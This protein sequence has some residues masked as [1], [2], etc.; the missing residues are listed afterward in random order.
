MRHEEGHFARTGGLELF[1]QCW[2]REGDP[3]AVVAL[4]HGVGEHSG[5]YM[6][7][8][9]PLVD[10]GYA[11]YGYDQRG[12][13]RSPGPRVHIDRWSDYREDLRAFLGL[14]A[15]HQPGRP[16]VVYG[17]SMGSLV[18]LDYLLQRPGG[19]A[20]AIISGVALQPA[21]VGKP[22][23]VAVVRVLSGVA[24]RLSLD[25][26][27][28]AGSLTR[29]PEALE[30]ARTD[31]LLTSRATV[32][33]GAE[34]LATVRRVNEDMAT[35]DLPLLVLHGGADPLNRPAGAL[36]LFNAVATPD[37]RLRIYPGVRHEPHN[38]LG[39]EQVA[40]DVKEWLAHLTA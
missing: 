17:H 33:W 20:G 4:V 8:V 34:S 37:K 28:G 12:H 15:A 31:P 40:A 14:V 21:G 1:W 27:I 5:R 11:V 25:L 24:P 23:Q 26:G 2:R 36:A 18:V 32:R 35:I 7:L 29:D 30:A 22:Y 10:D 6:N 38:D 3:R 19:L 13:G 16:L 39:H 9:R